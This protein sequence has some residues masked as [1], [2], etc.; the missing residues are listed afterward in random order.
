MK[1]FQ[2]AADGTFIGMLKKTET[3]PMIRKTRESPHAPDRTVAQACSHARRKDG[4]RGRRPEHGCRT[5]R[6]KVCRVDW[7]HAA[8]WGP[9]SSMALYAVSTTTV[10]DTG[11]SRYAKAP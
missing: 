3:S 8:Q 1:R 11:L 2:A 10:R 4:R 9:F 5:L 6:T 7:P